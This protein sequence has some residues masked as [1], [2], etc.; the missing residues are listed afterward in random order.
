M[1]LMRVRTLLSHACIVAALM[2]LVFFVI[3]RINPAMEFLTS[4]ISK[5][6]ILAFAVLSFTNAVLTV[7]AARRAVR[8]RL[9]R[10]Q[11]K[12]PV[13]TAEGRQAEEHI[14]LPEMHSEHAEFEG[15]E[16]VP[17]AEIIVKAN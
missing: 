11:D 16:P 12:A 13:Q 14:V 8:R 9:E 4:E 5:W 2:L 7:H 1:K 10:Q 15:P 17:A 6:F 3:D